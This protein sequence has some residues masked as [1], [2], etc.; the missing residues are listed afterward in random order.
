M[1]E[2]IETYTM[3]SCLTPIRKTTPEPQSQ[4][5]PSPITDDKETL[6]AVASISVEEN[7]TFVYCSNGTD[8]A[9]DVLSELGEEIISDEIIEAVVTESVKNNVEKEIVRKEENKQRRAVKRKSRAE[10]AVEQ[11]V[12]EERTNRELEK[13]LKKR[14][15]ML[16]YLN[17]SQGNRV[18]LKI[19]GTRFETCESTLKKDPESLFSLLFSE[20]TPTRDNYFIDRDPA[21]FRIILNYLRCGCSLPSESILPRELKYLLDIQSEYDFYN[22][23]GLK[24]IVDTRLRRFSEPGF[25]N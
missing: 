8:M 18:L 12:E 11:E 6:R 19:G 17:A 4:P 25:P 14:N 20:E 9:D 3:P 2:M 10:K 23:K 16:T 7:E 13:K 1:V 22:L 15:E 24:E 5:P 21:H